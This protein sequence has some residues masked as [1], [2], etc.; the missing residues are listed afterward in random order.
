MYF[1]IILEF[2]MSQERDTMLNKILY[3]KFTS[4]LD[5]VRRGGVD[6][7]TLESCISHQALTYFKFFYFLSTNEMEAEISINRR[8]DQKIYNSRADS[9]VRDQKGG[10]NKNGAASPRVYSVRREFL[11]RFV[12]SFLR[13]K[14]TSLQKFPS[15]R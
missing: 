4:I 13:S 12:F 7:L 8:F 15:R 11:C 1:H 6:S 5:G 14:S 10:R 2:T 3:L 9:E